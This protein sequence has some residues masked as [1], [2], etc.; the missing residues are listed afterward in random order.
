MLAPVVM[1]I[2]MGLATC[3]VEMHMGQ[4]FCSELIGQEPQDVLI[5]DLVLVL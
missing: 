3:A 2:A 1:I 5:Y 4:D